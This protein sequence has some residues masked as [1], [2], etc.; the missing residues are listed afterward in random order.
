MQSLVIKPTTDLSA[1]LQLP[2]GKVLVGGGLLVEFKFSD[3]DV[4]DCAQLIQQSGVVET[5]ISQSQIIV[6][7]GNNGWG[8]AYQQFK[9]LT[10]NPYVLKS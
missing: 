7:A 1:V 6:R 3:K 2:K 4:L 5:F 8:S 10:K 9:S